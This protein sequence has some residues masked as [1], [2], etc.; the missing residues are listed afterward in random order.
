MRKGLP[1]LIKQK[2]DKVNL[3]GNL[4]NKVSRLLAL[5]LPPTHYFTAQGIPLLTMDDIIAEST[6]GPVFC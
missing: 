2:L 1:N 5:T 6:K 3:M 4:S